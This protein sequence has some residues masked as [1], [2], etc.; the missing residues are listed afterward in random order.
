MKLFTALVFLPILASCSSAI[1]KPE[2]EVLKK[3]EAYELRKYEDLAVVT[4]PMKS[5]NGR[6]DSFGK[7]FQYISGE[8]EK[9]QKID[10]T[11]PVF[12]DEGKSA[13]K[14]EGSMSFV[15]PKEI[16]LKKAPDPN[17]E[18]VQLDTIEGGTYAVLRFKGWRDEEKQKQA[19]EALVKW[20]ESEK[21][22]PLGSTFYAFYNPPWTPEILRRNEVWIRIDSKSIKSK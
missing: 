4:A 22:K 16:D 19:A 14:R 2:Y 12:M 7:L 5:M 10:M 9:K 8:N 21:L 17:N 18:N 11:S 6:N 3:A 13:T 15:L 1:E 20:V